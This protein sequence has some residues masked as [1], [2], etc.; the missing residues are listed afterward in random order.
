MAEP[1][2]AEQARVTRTYDRAAAVYDAC[3]G[4]MN[5]IG[6]RHRRRRL[7]R[8]VH[9][10][11]LEVGIGTGRNLEHYPPDVTLTGIDVSG[12]MLGRAGHRAARLGRTVRLLEADVQSLPFADA[13]FDTVLATCVFCSVADPKRGLTEIRRVGGRAG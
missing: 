12:R 2:Q 5:L 10:A 9:G 7:V 8:R 1:W 6:G 4:V 3:D 13:S 11:T